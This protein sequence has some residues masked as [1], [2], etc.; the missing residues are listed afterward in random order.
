MTWSMRSLLFALILGAFSWNIAHVNA[1]VGTVDVNTVNA[2]SCSMSDVQSA[3]NRAHDGQT[4]AIPGGTCTWTKTL[5]VTN[6][7]NLLGAGPGLTVIIDNV[8]RST[9]RDNPALFMNI[10]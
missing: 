9:C 1:V 8:D 2:A 7:I 3:L 6:A 10:S 5:T 4:V